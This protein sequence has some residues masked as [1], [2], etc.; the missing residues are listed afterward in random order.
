MHNSM[1]RFK[2]NGC[3]IMETATLGFI[4]YLNLKA[5]KFPN[6][7]HL[8]LSPCHYSVTETCKAVFFSVL[9]SY[10]WNINIS[11]I[12]VLHKSKD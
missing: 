5:K 8:F 9:V 12:I 11:I 6:R 3:F 1:L 10:A 4:F 2:A 7:S